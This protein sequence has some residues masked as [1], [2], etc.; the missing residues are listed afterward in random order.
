MPLRR[1]STNLHKGKVVTIHNYV[2]IKDDEIVRAIKVL[3]AD[4]TN[5]NETVSY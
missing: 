4:I 2:G 3:T 1:K 5:G